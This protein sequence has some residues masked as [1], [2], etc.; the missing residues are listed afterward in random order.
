M[1]KLNNNVKK[2]LELILE[3]LIIW[4]VLYWI[5]IFVNAYSENK[6]SEEREIF[7]K[8]ES[9]NIIKKLNEFQKVISDSLELSSIKITWIYFSPNIEFKLKNIWNKEIDWIKFSFILEDNFWDQ[10]ENYDS[11]DN[12]FTEKAYTIQKN[13]LNW[14]TYIWSFKTEVLQKGFD[15]ISENTNIKVKWIEI[16]DIHFTDW[17]RLNRDDITQKTWLYSWE[18]Y[19]GVSDKRIILNNIDLK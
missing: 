15:M 17:T 1:P 19:Y 16:Y 9:Q 7:I 5:Y 10:I 2:I 6:Y 11:G 18:S 3:V 4:W 8:Q 12:I 14:D 13:L